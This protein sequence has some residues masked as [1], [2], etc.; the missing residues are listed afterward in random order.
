MLW[1]RALPKSAIDVIGPAF[2]HTRQQ[3]LQ[4]FRFGQW[5]RL[6]L[7]GLATGELTAGGSSNGG[8]RSLASMPSRFPHP[9]QNLVDPKDIFRGLDPAILGMMVA[10]LVMGGIILFV[11][12]TYMASVSRFVLFESVLRKRA[13]LS[14]GWA[15]WH[16]QGMRFF[17]W[18]L[19][20]AIVS[21][22]VGIVLLIPLFVP[23]VAAARSGHFDPSI[24]L[25][26]LPWL[27]VLAVFGFLMILIAVLAKDFVVPIMAVEDVGVIEGWRRLLAMMTEAK[28]SY[29][30]YVGTKVVLSISASVVFG[31]FSGILAFLLLLPVAVAG[32]AV[33]LFARGAG[34]TWDVFTITAAMVVGAVLLVVLMYVIALV[35]VPIAVFFPAYAMYFLAERLPRLHGLLYPAPIP[36]AGSATL[37][38]PPP[39]PPTP[40]PIG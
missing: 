25:A 31:I 6:A 37:P 35:C 33:F 9:S 39:I 29:A 2:E 12:W 20:M 36:V 30:A 13:E 17:G 19:A 23:L 11:V 26:F 27:L 4:P 28:G 18:N 7:L 8:L 1:E 16:R 40:E 22:A 24:L 15:R 32:V 14:R 3:L 5:A 34:L 38:H 10:V 21:M